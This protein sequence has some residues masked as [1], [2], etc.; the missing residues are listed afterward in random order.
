MLATQTQDAPSLAGIYPVN[1]NIRQSTL[2]QLVKDAWARDAA[3][4]QDVVPSAVRAKFKLMSDREIVH[5]MHF[6]DTPLEAKAAR[7]SAVFREFFLFETQIQALR[8]DNQARPM[9]WQF[10]TTI[11]RCAH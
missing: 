3:N 5:G 9:G 4:I 8:E 7:R 2:V 1:K 6:P 11:K 10:L